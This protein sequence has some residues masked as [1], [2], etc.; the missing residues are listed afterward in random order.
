MQ[1]LAAP[2]LTVERI[3]LDDSELREHFATNSYKLEIIDDG[4]W[5][6]CLNHSTS[7]VIG[8]IYAQP[9]NNIGK[10]MFCK[11]TSVSSVYW[12]RASKQ[13]N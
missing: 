1:E 5:C 6:W 10:L 4:N 3:E 8:M 12:R 11:L 13:N 2:K 7:K 9:A